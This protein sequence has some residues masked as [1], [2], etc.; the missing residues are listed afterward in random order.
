MINGRDQVISEAFERYR[1]R[2]YNVAYKI[3][4]DS[5]D[6]KD[7]VMETFERAFRGYA[8]YEEKGLMYCWLRR[9]AVNTAIGSIKKS[10]R[11]LTLPFEEEHPCA[12]VGGVEEEV[13]SGI[14]ANDLMKE[15][16]RNLPDHQIP[17]MELYVG[18]WSYGEISEQ[19]R[20]S[21]G[22]VRSRL[23]RARDILKS[24]LLESLTA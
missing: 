20:I 3:V 4:G 16:R 12:G 11:R 13:L 14:V 21:I 17:T 23:S 9:I 1:D 7:V 24:E 19:L 8:S 22:T 10:E 6:A 5:E 2:L 15:L 18:G